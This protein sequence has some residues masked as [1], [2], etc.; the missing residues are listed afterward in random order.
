MK[1]YIGQSVDIAN[2]LTQHCRCGCGIKTPKDNKLYAAML[3]EGLDQFTFEV[4]ELCP[5]EELNEKKNIILMYII[6]L[7]MVS[8]HRMV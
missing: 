3:K 1:C 2:R 5:Q 4:V 7:T 8:I 6:Q